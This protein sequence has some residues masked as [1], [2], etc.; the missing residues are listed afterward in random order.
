MSR[1]GL[2][3]SRKARDTVRAYRYRNGGKRCR[4]FWIVSKSSCAMG[5]I[6]EVCDASVA[7]WVGLDG[8]TR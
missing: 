4:F 3:A 5:K 2:A 8:C 6:V 7:A 1:R